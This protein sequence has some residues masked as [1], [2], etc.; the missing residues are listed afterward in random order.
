[1]NEAWKPDPL[2]KYTTPTRELR[3][4]LFGLPFVLV[5]LLSR[6]T[7]V[8]RERLLA[9]VRAHQTRG[10]GLVTVSNHLS[11][12]DDP[13]VF[14]GLLGLLDFTERTKC[15]YST[16]CAD[17]FNPLDGSL[18][19]R[20]VRS[21]ADIANLVLLSR[22]HKRE[23]QGRSPAPPADPVLEL[24]SRLDERLLRRAEVRAHA[25]G[26]GFERYLRSFVT[27]GLVGE[28]VAALNQAGLLEACLRAD[29][30]D[31]VHIFPE[32]GRSRDG[33]L[34]PAR[35]GAGKLIHQARDATVLPL[36]IHGTED[37]LPIGATFPRLGRRI[38]VVVGEP[39]SSL[40]LR[41]APGG[42]E[43]F[44]SLSERALA[45]VAALQPG[46][47]APRPPSARPRRRPSGHAV[48]MPPPS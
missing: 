40:E 34:R 47:A 5:A 45:A 23:A 46:A 21:F 8:G 3:S 44:Q 35:A 1:M 16:A 7:V 19:S 22:A 42:V 4:R 25:R 11:L 31:W 37:V 12:F 33:R 24:L 17:N 10:H 13:L 18:R 39:L 6:W 20:V 38:T 32:G 36:W 29:A 9:A 27:G 15:W 28:R 43:V 26:L 30:G 48:E 2:D 41:R 14:V